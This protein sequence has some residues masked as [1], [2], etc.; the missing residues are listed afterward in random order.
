[1][2]DDSGVGSAGYNIF[3]TI[4]ICKNTGHVDMDNDGADGAWEIA[5]L[6][7]DKFEASP[8]NDLNVDF[9]DAMIT[10]LSTVPTPKDME[11]AKTLFSNLGTSHS[12][13][14]LIALQ[15]LFAKKNLVV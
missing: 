3:L 14:V 10:F 15:E 13:G 9:Q 12:L 2:N 7:L 8:C 1:M 4:G 5:S 6:L 11:S